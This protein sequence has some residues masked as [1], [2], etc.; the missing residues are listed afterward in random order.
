M[1]SLAPKPFPAGAIEVAA[2]PNLVSFMP[3]GIRVVDETETRFFYVPSSGHMRR[4]GDKKP[5]EE[6]VTISGTQ[7]RVTGP[8]PPP[9]CADNAKPADVGLAN[10]DK[11]FIVPLGSEIMIPKFEGGIFHKGRLFTVPPGGPRAYVDEHGR[12]VGCKGLM[13]LS[14]VL[15]D[16]VL[17]SYA[18]E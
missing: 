3:C 11:D 17:A 15:L 10:L 6:L 7:F 13:P 1:S 4:V 5:T 16:V 18:E 14:Q 9:P 12:V 2:P 8:V